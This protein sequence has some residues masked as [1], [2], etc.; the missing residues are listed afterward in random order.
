MPRGYEQIKNP[1]EWP[2]SVTVTKAVAPPP[3]P[4]KPAIWP[5]LPSPKGVFRRALRGAKFATH[6]KAKV[7]EKRLSN[8]VG[9]TLPAT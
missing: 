4:E 5:R 7:E 1:V 6:I 2:Q 8:K 3:A 9:G